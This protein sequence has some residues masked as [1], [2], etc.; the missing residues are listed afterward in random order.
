M[1]GDRLMVNGATFYACHGALPQERLR[2]QPFS[3]DVVLDLP[4]SDAGRQD[5]LELSVDYRD[6]WEA[7][8]SVMEGPPKS[9]LEALAEEIADR[10]YHPPV[11]GL[12]VRVTKLCPPLPGPTA[13][14][15]AEI[16]RG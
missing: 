15:A 12:S 14:T 11:T 16:C 9:L 4:L 2:P 8:R 5:A 10:L 13:S 7:V 3:V 1:M 6:I